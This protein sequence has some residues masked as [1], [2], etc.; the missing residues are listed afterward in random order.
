M[1]S[2]GKSFEP[3]YYAQEQKV[4]KY[5]QKKA[6]NSSRSPVGPNREPQLHCSAQYESYIQKSLGPLPERNPSPNV[7][8]SRLEANSSPKV[9]QMQCIDSRSGQ[10]A[11][12]SPTTSPNLIETAFKSKERSEM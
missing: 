12:R 11:S 6:R 7:L 9:H 10:N 8:V 5:L 2:S 3:N 4:S 1:L